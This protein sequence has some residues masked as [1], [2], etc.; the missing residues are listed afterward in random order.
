VA[1]L[2]SRKAIEGAEHVDSQTGAGSPEEIHF[3]DGVLLASHRRDR[4]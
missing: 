3:I 4:S 1:F 2:D